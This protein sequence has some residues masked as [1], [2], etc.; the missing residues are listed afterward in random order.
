MRLLA[1]AR[2]HFCPTECSLTYA[3]AALMALRL[4]AYDNFFKMSIY[5]WEQR[6]IFE[7][8][9]SARHDPT[10]KNASFH[11]ASRV[12]FR[13]GIYEKPAALCSVTRLACPAGQLIRQRYLLPVHAGPFPSE[14][15]R[16]LLCFLKYPNRICSLERQNSYFS[17][18]SIC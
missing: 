3:I 13:S 12:W 2:S 6:A 8:N 16:V 7:G 17:S 4:P 9:K 11:S 18:A 10:R 5:H 15:T 1:R 14:T